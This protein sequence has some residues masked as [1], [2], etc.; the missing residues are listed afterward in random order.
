MKLRLYIYHTGHCDPK[1]CTARKLAKYKLALILN[2]IKDL[3]V[4]L[5][6]LDPT[7]EKALS[8]E[9][10]ER[11]QRGIAALDCSWE[12]VAQVFPAVRRKKLWR[13]ALPFFTSS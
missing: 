2:D 1:K 3:P 13:R 11:A 4:N 8:P 7:A 12:E 6:F 9:D 10:K 5:L